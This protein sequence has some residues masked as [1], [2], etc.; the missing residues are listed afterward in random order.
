MVVVGLTTTDFLLGKS[1]RK[2]LQSQL[3]DYWLHLSEIR[4]PTLGLAEATA[5]LRFIDYVFG[6]KLLSLHRLLSTA[7]AVGLMICV[8][9]M[10]IELG[11][12]LI[13]KPLRWPFEEPH[14]NTAF[15]DQVIP[16]ALSISITRFLLAQSIKLAGHGKWSTLWF[17]VATS[18]VGAFSFFAALAIGM[19]MPMYLTMGSYVV[20]DGIRAVVDADVVG[21]SSRWWESLVALL[22]A[23]LAVTN[24]ILVLAYVNTVH[25]FG[26]F[27]LVFLEQAMSSDDASQFPIWYSIVVAMG[28]G[29]IRLLF[30]FTFVGSWVLMP[31]LKWFTLLILLRLAETEKGALT[32]LS[33]GMA[34]VA[35]LVQ[36]VAKAFLA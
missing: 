28:F 12:M 14:W 11:R 8:G 23:V 17:L 20:S 1:G 13:G 24:L 16:A 6:P 21:T 27:Y 15:P 30:A 7:V 9:Y 3:E 5:S 22:N 19:A 2:R 32:A 31:P 26:W 18:V 35:K 10:A 25:V 36:Q 33:I 34:L 4:L 29:L